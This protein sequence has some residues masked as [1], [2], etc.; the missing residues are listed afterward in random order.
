[1]KLPNLRNVDDL[2]N[3]NSFDTEP[4]Y[5]VLCVGTVPAYNILCVGAVLGD[6]LHHK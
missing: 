1:M 4:E 5:N 6:K 2:Q 3:L